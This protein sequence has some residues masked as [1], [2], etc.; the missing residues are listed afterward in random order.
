VMEMWLLLTSLAHNW[1]ALNCLR[2]RVLVFENDR[3]T[4][5]L[6]LECLIEPALCIE[7]MV[8]ISTRSGSS[9][10][11]RQCRHRSSNSSYGS[12]STSCV[13]AW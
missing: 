5:S 11:R 8:Q 7:L 9:C 2:D 3:Y 13:G 6:G 12:V 4:T 1:I 10:V